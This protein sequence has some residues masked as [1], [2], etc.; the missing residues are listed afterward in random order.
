MPLVRPL[1]GANRSGYFLDLA[2]FS[3]SLSAFLSA[4]ILVSSVAVSCSWSI[5][6]SSRDIESRSLCFMTISN[7]GLYHK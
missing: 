2:S 4:A 1:R 6:S 5:N 3:R 7:F